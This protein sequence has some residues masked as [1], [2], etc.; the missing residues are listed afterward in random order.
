MRRHVAMDRLEMQHKDE[1]QQLAAAAEVQRQ[2]RS[3]DND[4]NAE[5]YVAACRVEQATKL[6]PNLD[7]G[8]V[9]TFIRML[10]LN[11]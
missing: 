9:D 8:D 1:L 10:L 4:D 3:A 7:E 2:Q 5:H 6:I 11:V